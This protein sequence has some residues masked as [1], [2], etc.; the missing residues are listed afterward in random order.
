VTVG[1]LHHS[2]RRPFAGNWQDKY[3][4]RHRWRR[5]R[6]S[7]NRDEGVQEQGAIAVGAVNCRRIRGNGQLVGVAGPMCMDGP[8][9]VV[10]GHVIVG[11]GVDER[12]AQGCGLDGQREREGENLPHDV[13][14]FVTGA[15]CVKGSWSMG[16]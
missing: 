12:S 15:Y 4:A 6:R 5:I 13:P 2:T 3:A 14:L 7:R 11:M 8:P 9:V 10:L 1:D 16:D